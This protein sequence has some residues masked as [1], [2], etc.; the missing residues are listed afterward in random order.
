MKNICVVTGTRAEYHLLF[1]LLKRLKNDPELK[2]I[3]AVT[4]SHLNAA[5]GNT[6][7]DIENDGFIIDKKIDILQK[8]DK[9]H[10]INTA[11]C[12]AIEGFDIFF[13]EQKPDIIILLGDRYELLSVAIVAMNYQIPIAHIHGGETTEGA[14]DE[15]IRHSIT[16]MSY[17][18]FTSCE[19]YRNR[20]IQLGENPDR[21][22]NVGGLGVENIKNVKLMTL[23][24]LEESLD[25]PLKERFAVVTFHPVTLEADTAEADFLKVLQALEQ[26]DHLKVIFTKANADA[27]GLRINSLIDAYVKERPEQCIAV[28]SLGLVRYLTAL[29]YAAIVIGN[30]S[31]GILETPSFGVPTVNIGDRQ[32]GRIQARNIINCQIETEAIVNAIKRGLD[33]K[34]KDYAAGAI[35]PYGEGH[36]SE[37]IIRIIKQTLYASSINL[38]KQFYDVPINQ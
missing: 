35:S 6:Y 17:L 18:H 25:F 15:C 3:L 1:Q 7:R 16:K 4:G 28:Y 27:G 31:S 34:F 5:Y 19:E 2:L 20:V 26:I 8:E 24:E 36:A 21:V 11:M 29:K 32:R 38:K 13:S 30:S 9:T 10:D 22:F 14:I 33:E 23:A 12:K 37:Q